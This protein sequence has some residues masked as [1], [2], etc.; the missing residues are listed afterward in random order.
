[1]EPMPA[2]ATAYYLFYKYFLNYQ[3]F[4]ISTFYVWLRRV[5][6]GSRKQE[7]E[8]EREEKKGRDFRG[9]KKTNKTKKKLSKPKDSRE[10][11]AV[12]RV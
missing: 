4:L 3:R 1:M 12:V 2:A 7:A 10:R 5:Q 11:V 9:G 6:K 8:K